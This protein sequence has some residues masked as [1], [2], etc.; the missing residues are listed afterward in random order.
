MRHRQAHSDRAAI[1]LLVENVLVQSDH[2]G[3]IVDHF[4]EMVERIAEF[5]RRRSVAL[6]ESGVV[7]R[8][9]MIAVGQQRDQRS[10]ARCR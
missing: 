5:G 6:A 1:V 3:E 7:R 10:A 8:D 2:L 4:R 9:K